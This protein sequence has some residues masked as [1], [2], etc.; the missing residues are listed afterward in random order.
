MRAEKN[1][2]FS[3]RSV[4]FCIVPGDR[5]NPQGVKDSPVQRFLNGEKRQ[6]IRIKL[7]GADCGRAGPSQRPTSKVFQ[8]GYGA[9]GGQHDRVGAGGKP[10]NA[11]FPRFLQHVH[12]HYQNCDRGKN[13]GEEGESSQELTYEIELEGGYDAEKP[14]HPLAAFV[15]VFHDL[16]GLKIW[17]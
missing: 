12:A 9:P 7:D 4:S 10:G 16:V 14:P 11:N 8:R 5:H 6:E 2:P 13:R 3:G 15:F 1:R 17:G